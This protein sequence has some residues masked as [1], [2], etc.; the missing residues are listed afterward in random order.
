MAR[1]SAGARRAWSPHRPGPSTFIWIV[2]S[3][4]ALL[5]LSRAL[6]ETGFGLALRLVTAAA[7]VLLLPGALV[8]RVFSWPSQLGVALAGA[9]IWSLGIVSVALGITFV[10]GASLSLTVALVGVAASVAF[11]P[12]LW[13]RPA[14]TSRSDRNT[15]LGLAVVGLVLGIAVW[16]VAETVEGDGLF[17]AARVRKLDELSELPSVSALNEFADGGLHPGYAFPVWHGVLALI[18]RLAAVD[19]V[20]VVQFLPALLV[21]LALV[22]AYAAGAALFRSWAA[23]LATAAAQAGLVA[24]SRDG[25]GSFELLSLPPAAARLLI[26]SALLAVVFALLAG[27]PRRTLVIVGL[28]GLVLGIVHPTYV[29]YVALGLAGFAVARVVLTRA[30]GLRDAGCA[31]AAIVAM[32]LPAGIYFAWLLP[33]VRQTASFRPDAA[34]VVRGTE[35]YEDQLDRFGDLFRLAPDSIA[36]GGVVAVVGLVAVVL[37]IL[38]PRWRATAYVVGASLVMLIAL[39]VPALFTELSDAVSLS[40]SRR[41]PAFLPVPFAFAAGALLVARLRLSGV[42]IAAGLGVVLVV[43]SAGEYVGWLSDGGFGWAAWAGLAGGVAVIVIGQVVRDRVEGPS[44][45]L[46]VALVALAFVLPVAIDGLRQLEQEPADPRALSPGLVEAIR[47]DV[48]ARAVVFAD[49]ETS[50][51]IA[52]MAPVSIAAAPPSHVADTTRNRPYERRS[53]V[54]LFFF[55]DV[56]DAARIRVLRRFDAEWLVVDKER[57]VPALVGELGPPSYEDDRWLLLQVP[58]ELTSP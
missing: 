56:A 54:V 1:L 32:L 17:H 26:T 41:L 9:F 4:P 16:W 38:V 27:A 11:V 33:V 31:A 46:W 10:A 15:I 35:R 42:A 47:G 45:E 6:P 34:E 37:L 48:P 18:A 39:L 55:R 7:C 52:A 2:L 28:G 50:Y 22:F 20:A 44:R 23:G 49:L 53:A 36:R 21:P 13:S 40:Q 43:L 25:V 19:A 5:G 14:A 3:G 29:L 57:V 24:F 51:R 58:M 30:G 12:A 8:L